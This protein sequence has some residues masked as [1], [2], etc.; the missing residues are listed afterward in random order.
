MLHACT[1][2]TRSETGCPGTLHLDSRRSALFSSGL[3]ETMSNSHGQSTNS[4]RH[5]HVG[6]CT[7]LARRCHVQNVKELSWQRLAIQGRQTC[8]PPKTPLLQGVLYRSAKLSFGHEVADNPS[9]AGYR[10]A[11]KFRSPHT[12]PE[13]C[14]KQ[15]RSRPRSSSLS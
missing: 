10:K 2:L 7:R 11:I 5:S 6:L 9:Q 8:L 15:T 13:R 14:S 12:I 3:R 1:C 4:L